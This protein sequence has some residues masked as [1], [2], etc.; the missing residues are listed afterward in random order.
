MAEDAAAL[1]DHLG[2]KRCHVCGQSMGS[3]IGQELA[4]G[5]P[6]LVHT[7]QLHSTWDRPYPHLSRQLL[8]RRELARREE[9]E[10]FA[11]NSAQ[12]LFPPAYANLHEDELT[13][14]Q[15]LLF[16]KHATSHG[17]VG[18]YDADLAFESVGRLGAIAAPTLIT[19]GSADITT[20]PEYNRRV[21]EQ[22]AG[23]VMHVFE[24]AGHLPFVEQPELFNWLTLGFLAQHP[25]REP[26]A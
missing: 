4:I 17:L 15:A 10:L 18:H 7:L 6:E 19:V 22:I 9:W 23:S 16:E 20:L 13:R 2:V 14:R 8:F 25:M 26:S 11:L 3:A 5:W 12:L 21:H 1:L 24:G